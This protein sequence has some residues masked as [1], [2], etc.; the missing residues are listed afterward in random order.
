MSLDSILAH[1]DL[2]GWAVLLGS[3]LY[4]AGLVWLLVENR[5]FEAL[6]TSHAGTEDR[7]TVPRTEKVSSDSQDHAVGG[8][9]V[10]SDDE[11]RPHRHGRG[12][13]TGV[14]SDSGRRGPW[15]G[16]TVVS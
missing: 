5:S 10:K 4:L 9:P 15:P 6:N 7:G 11:P 3:L 14:G 16:V 12:N 8:A 1:F 2:L 13:Q